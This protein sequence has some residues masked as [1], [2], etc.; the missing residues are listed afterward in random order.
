[1]SDYSV[2]L[3][4]TE[5]NN[6]VGLI[7]LRQGDVASQSIQ[8]TI[9]ANGQLFNFDHLAIF[10]NA[11]LPNGYVVRDK[12]TNVDY[13]NSKLNYV[14]A[15]SFLQEVAQVTAW[16]SFENDEKIIDSTKN[17]QYSVIG[18]WKECIP[19]GNYIYELSEIQREIEEIIGNKDFTPLISKIS[20]LETDVKY[21][22]NSKTSKEEFAQSNKVLSDT[23]DDLENETTA[24]LAQKVGNGKLAS[25]ADMGQDVKTAMT[26][27]S[28]AVVG[29]NT[30]IEKNVVDKQ[31]TPRKTSFLNR[32]SINVFDAQALKLGDSYN[33][34]SIT[35]GV[36]VTKELPSKAPFTLNLD[37]LT[38]KGKGIQT[39]KAGKWYLKYKSKSTNGNIGVGSGV[40]PP[41]LYDLN[42][43]RNNFVKI[44][45]ENSTSFAE[46]VWELDLTGDAVNYGLLFQNGDFAE[47]YTMFDFMITQNKDDEYEDYYTY[48][49]TKNIR[50]KEYELLKKDVDVIK[51]TTLHG[52]HIGDSLTEGDYGSVTSGVPNLKPLNYP[53]FFKE[54]TGYTTTNFGKS[55]WTTKQVW[56][57]VVKTM[58]LSSNYNFFIIMLGTNGGLTDTIEIDCAGEDYNLYADTQTGSY[59]KI[60]EHLM[61][62]CPSAQLF[63]C[64][65]PF[66]DKNGKKEYIEE[67]GEVVKKIGKKYNVS[68]IDLYGELGVNKLNKNVFLPIDNLHFGVF[69]YQKLGTFIA[70]QV[71][72]KIGYYGK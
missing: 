21:L 22:D 19:Q 45:G 49:P 65:P 1:M 60:I 61:I 17:F 72:S 15:D 23:I 27:G 31:I 34:L 39:L 13:A 20:S 4:T 26:G 48:Y 59:C 63:L 46:W 33:I 24:Q 53:Y 36:V 66:N 25:M 8:A 47:T 7:K 37:N 5:P 69:G 18:G 32:E 11:V 56:D 52:G 3:S 42:A 38:N 58:S 41:R 64:T 6:Y 10:F 50:S 55:G 44:K 62:N 14:V 35:N 12:V 67:S 71:L 54:E 57:G 29:E 2:T 16:F 51:R 43:V 70:N 68:V 40:F 28:V 30:V 9:T